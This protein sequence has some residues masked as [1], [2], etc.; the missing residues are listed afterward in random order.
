MKKVKIKLGMDV[1]DAVVV[2]DSNEKTVQ[3]ELLYEST[4]GSGV[5]IEQ[6]RTGVI[7]KRHRVKHV[8]E[9]L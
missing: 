4:P 1:V 6:R 8:V 3:V 9:G 2:D 7:V 5:S